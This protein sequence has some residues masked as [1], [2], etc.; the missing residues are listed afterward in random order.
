MSDFA[1]HPTK[2]AIGGRVRFNLTDDDMVLIGL[3]VTRFMDFLRTRGINPND[4]HARNVHMDLGATHSNGCPLDL[5][6]LMAMEITPFVEDIMGIGKNLDRTTGKL[7][8]NYRPRC[9]VTRTGL[10]H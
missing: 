3:I 9:A 10:I 5:S 4:N 6:A 7:L 8:N 2:Q 1:Q